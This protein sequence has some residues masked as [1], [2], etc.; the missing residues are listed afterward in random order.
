GFAGYFGG[1]LPE[2]KGST[3]TKRAPNTTG[4][5]AVYASQTQNATIIFIAADCLDYC[6]GKP[7]IVMPCMMSAVRARILRM[8]W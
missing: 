8:R 7:A 2:R 5:S 4:T 6:A 3:R 1:D